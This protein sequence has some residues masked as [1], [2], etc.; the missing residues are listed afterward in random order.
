MEIEYKI[1]VNGIDFDFDTDDP[2]EET[3]DVSKEDHQLN[4]NYE[5]ASGRTY[6][7]MAHDREDAIYA[8]MDEITDETGWFIHSIDCEFVDGENVQTPPRVGTIDS[9]GFENEDHIAE[10]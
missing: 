1:V 2:W 6:T 4:L 10:M 5:W 3:M 8:M 7:V 9:G